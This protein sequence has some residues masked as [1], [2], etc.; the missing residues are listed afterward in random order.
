M[1]P[2]QLQ[3]VVEFLKANSP[4]SFRAVSESNAQIVVD[5]ISKTTHEGVLRRAYQNDQ[6]VAT[7]EQCE[8]A[9]EDQMRFAVCEAL[10][11]II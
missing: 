2:D 8:E 5:E 11:I 9:S 1:T 7:T 6:G 10:L 4:K 3:S